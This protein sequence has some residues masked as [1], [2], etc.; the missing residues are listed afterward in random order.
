MMDDADYDSHLWTIPFE[1]R[2]SLYLFLA[3]LGTS[4][5]RR[6]YRVALIG[7][8]M[9]YVWGYHRWDTV[10]FLSGMLI[11]EWDHASG[12]HLPPSVLPSTHVPKKTPAW[13]FAFWVALNFLSMFLMGVP[14]RGCVDTPFYKPFCRAVPWE[15]KQRWWQALGVIPFVITVPRLWWWKKFY[16]TPVVQYLG[17]IS[18]SLYLMHGM[19][20]KSVG[21]PLELWIWRHVTGIKG[22]NRLFGWVLGALF[23]VSLAI[24]LADIFMRLI[25]IPAVKFTKWVES[26]VTKQ[27]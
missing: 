1:F 16:E 25:D 10:L 18:Y 6:R 3:I 22:Y 2:N 20:L 9:L 8:V 19:V 4:K 12:A 24:W 7:F 11:A 17:R 15:S 5:L 27:D 13:Q 26:K 23:T 14:D 21:M